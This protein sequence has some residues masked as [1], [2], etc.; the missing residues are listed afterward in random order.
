ML[1]MLDIDGTLCRS[2][3]REGGQRA[4]F[5]LVEFLPFRQAR[6]RALADEFG[7]CFALVTNQAGVAMGY[8]TDYQVHAKIGRILAGLEFFYGRPHSVHVCFTHDK[9]K[10]AHYTTQPGDDRRKPG[11][12]MLLEAMRVHGT[13]RTASRFVGD[14]QTD[15]QAAAAAG[16]EYVDA[17]AFF[18]P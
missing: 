10:L 6:L 7:A 2:F 16:V 1:T 18:I 8:Q 4:D 13:G 5:D 9:P 17:Q 11:P 15:E 14:M 12:G 3:L